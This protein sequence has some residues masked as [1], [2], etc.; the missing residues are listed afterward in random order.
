MQ[1]EQRPTSGLIPYAQNSRKHTPEQITQVANS[2]K[3]FGFLNPVI[4]DGDSGIIAGHC[5][6]M[7][8]NQLGL[9]SVPCLE[10]SHLNESQK[11]AYIIADN[12]LALNADW[13]YEN[14]RIEL[15]KLIDIDFDTDVLGFSEIEVMNIL[16][17]DI[18]TDAFDEWDGMPEFD[19]PDAKSF[20]HCIVHFESEDDAKEFFSLIGQPDTGKTKS[21]WHPQKEQRD[22]ESK[23]YE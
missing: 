1:I 7:A 17:M 22:I 10:A 19:Q 21:I 9:E 18:D 4:I 11:Q 12:K 20:R 14:L 23:R 6:V 13:D 3:E 2:I 5:R 15:N 8:A 16:N